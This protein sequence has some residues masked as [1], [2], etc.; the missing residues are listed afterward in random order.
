MKLFAS[1]VITLLLSACG[2]I[3]H[4]VASGIN[5]SQLRGTVGKSYSQ[6][7][8][9]RPDFGKLV[10]RESLPNGDEVM[11]HVGDFGTSTSSVGGVYGKQHQQARVIYFRVNKNGTIDD[12]ATEFYKAGTA[13]CWVGFCS[14]AKMEQVPVEELDRIV[15]TSAGQSIQSWRSRT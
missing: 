3:G 1:V 9:E 12:W 11:K 5:N 10:G 14:G 7:V 4:E 13:T 6:V 8:Y 2:S 15:K